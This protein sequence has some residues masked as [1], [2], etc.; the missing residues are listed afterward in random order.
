VI[1]CGELS[2]RNHLKDLGVEGSIIL[3]CIFKKREWS[4]DWIALDRDRW[5]TVVNAAMNLRFP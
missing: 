3:K 4:M 2:D 1:W 5:R